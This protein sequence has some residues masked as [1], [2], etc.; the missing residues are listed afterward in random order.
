MPLSE[1]QNIRECGLEKKKNFG[2]SDAYVS[3]SVDESRTAKKAKANE[4]RHE[5]PRLYESI[6]G[7]CFHLHSRSRLSRVLSARA[8][9]RHKNIFP[10]N[11]VQK[12]PGI[13]LRNE[14]WEHPA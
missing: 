5:R 3:E 7:E 8:Y 11:E 1:L 12:F 6:R 13:L 9:S 14:L 2:K 10:R 4:A